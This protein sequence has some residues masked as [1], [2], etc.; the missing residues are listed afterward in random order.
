MYIAGYTR[1]YCKTNMWEEPNITEFNK[2]VTNK[3]TNAREK[4]DQI[5]KLKTKNSEYLSVWFTN[6]GEKNEFRT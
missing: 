4:N 5:N 3:V 2:V 6:I 1:F